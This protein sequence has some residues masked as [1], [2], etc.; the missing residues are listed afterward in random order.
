MTRWPTG[1]PPSSHPSH[2][3]PGSWITRARHDSRRQ[4]LHNFG[5][6]TSVKHKKGT[7]KS[8]YLL[9]INSLQRLEI[10]FKDRRQF[11][12]ERPTFLLSLPEK[13]ETAPSFPQRSF[14]KRSTPMQLITLSLIS[15]REISF[16]QD[17]NYSTYNYST[18]NEAFSRV[19]LHLQSIHWS[20]L[21]NTKQFH[22]KEEPS[23]L[24]GLLAP[25]GALVVIMG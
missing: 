3:P 2:A 24:F 17:W 14:L 21:N 8:Y 7:R 25:S 10:D 15:C 12:S 20:T 13:A 19:K 6:P 9:F 23:S 22:V 18:Y 1:F 4:Y 16:K 11:L 5:F